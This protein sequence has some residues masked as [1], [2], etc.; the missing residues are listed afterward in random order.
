M[1]LCSPVRHSLGALP[2]TPLGVTSPRPPASSPS[3]RT[4][5]APQAA[6][7]CRAPSVLHLA[8]RVARGYER[9]EVL[10]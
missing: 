5:S 10:Q 8:Q 6:R 9:K 3:V 1:G 7:E 2:Q 4:Q